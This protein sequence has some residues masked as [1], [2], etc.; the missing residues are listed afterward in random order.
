MSTDTIITPPLNWDNP[1][2]G[3]APPV[4]PGGLTVTDPLVLTGTLLSIK[5]ASSTSNGFVTTSDQS[6]AGTKSFTSLVAS[7]ASVTTNLNV[8]QNITSTNLT[9]GQSIT[10]TDILPAAIDMRNPK[11]VMQKI[12]FIEHSYQIQI[13]LFQHRKQLKLM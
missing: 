6:F 9:V 7:T 11:G 2:S 12:S 5:Q 1:S 13:L 4:V 8:G 3:A 10:A